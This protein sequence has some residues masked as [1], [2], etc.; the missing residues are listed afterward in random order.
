M[1]MRNR[2]GVGALAA[3]IGASAVAAPASAALL[4]YP[5]PPMTV[6]DCTGGRI[7]M[8]GGNGL[9]TCDFYVPP[10]PPPPPPSAYPYVYEASMFWFETTQKVRVTMMVNFA[11]GGGGW[12]Q[13]AYST[14]DYTGYAGFPWGGDLSW[15]WS[16]SNPGSPADLDAPMQWF[17]TQGCRV[18]SMDASVQTVVSNAVAAA[19]GEA[20]PRYGGQTWVNYAACPSRVI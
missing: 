20:R 8:R 2:L 1:G 9:P 18:L 7:W 11:T 13:A 12:N 15:F 3:C 6:A 16:G 4:S 19:G 14:T 17:V 5:A 10:P